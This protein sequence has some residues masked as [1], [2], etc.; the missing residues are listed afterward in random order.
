MKNLTIQFIT[1]FLFV[2][3]GITQAQTYQ[4]AKQKSQHE[5]LKITKAEFQKMPNNQVAL[6]FEFM[7]PQSKAISGVS[8][9][10]D[11]EKRRKILVPRHLLTQFKN[12]RLELYSVTSG[13]AGKVQVYSA[14][15]LYTAVNLG[16][17]AV[18]VHAGGRDV[19]VIF[20]LKK[21]DLNQRKIS[22][23]G[24]EMEK[25]CTCVG[26]PGNYKYK[27]APIQKTCHG[28]PGMYPYTCYVCPN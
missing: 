28:G 20:E 19:S 8:I 3:S 27:C 15:L 10:S 17:F 24:A 22:L 6:K 2:F 9:Y 12:E 5:L 14:S 7:I 4:L 1:F 18:T 13:G 26:G 21:I 16:P 23:Y 25:S 11:F